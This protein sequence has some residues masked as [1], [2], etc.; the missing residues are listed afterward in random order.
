MLLR[1]VAMV[2]TLAFFTVCGLT[3]GTA[4][5][6]QV[7]GDFATISAAVAAANDGDTVRVYAGTYTEHVDVTKSIVLIGSGPD[8][9][10]TIVA[11]A[12]FATNSAYNYARANFTTERAI[13]HIGG[14]AVLT[15]SMQ[16]FTIDGSRLGPPATEGVAYAGVL[17]ERAII[18][19]ANNTIQ[20][21]LPADSSQTY[22]TT[23]NGRG[24]SVRG[25]SCLAN[26]TGNTLTE[27]NR[28]FIF[29][30]ATDNTGVLPAVFPVATISGNTITGKGTYNGAQKGIWL[31]NGC[32]GTIS[33]N[34]ITNMDYIDAYI[35]S[36]R[37]TAITIRRGYLNPG[38][39]NRIYGNTL[40]TGS[41]V[42]NKGIFAEGGRDSIAG[43]TVTGFRFGIQLDDEDSAMVVGNTVTGGQI[44]VMVSTTT[45]PQVA[46]YAITI[47]GSPAAKN[48]ITG[49]DPSSIGAAIAL[50]FRD[51]VA[52]GT[53]MSSIPVDARYNDLGVYS[54]AEVQ[55]RIWDRA[56]TTL[57]GVDTVY[58]H[59]FYTPKIRASV[60]VFLQGPY[61]AG[62]DLM[63][64]GLKTSGV[65]ATHFGATPFP[66]LAVDSITIE[67]RSAATAAGSTT[68]LYA[69]AWLLTDGSIRNFSD[70]T[71][72][73]VEF[74]TTLSGSYYLVVR[75]RNHL[76]IMCSTAHALDGGTSP[77]PYDFSTGQAQAYGTNPL[78]AVGT[79]YAM[80][81]GDVT[82]NG[83][84][85]Y[86][87]SANDRAPILTRVGGTSLT[88]TVN[89]YYPEDV[90]LNGQV[91]YSGSAND[92][93]VILTNVGGTS[94]TATRSTQVP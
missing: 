92:R 44:G 80:Y 34:T 54:E 55:E 91:K 12:D 8:T 50:S 11:P 56:D 6:L 72:T 59:P 84:L 81:C 87:G 93:A 23:Y 42:N 58:Y 18:T 15:V 70:T 5:T 14:S 68:R 33:G 31:N 71:K 89:G 25:D 76:A 61:N 78:V 74:D 37:A 27:I 64:N 17:A 41:F 7:P 9:T 48:T 79:R 32:L 67:L 82:G 46:A 66:G 45:I 29:I 26:I 75:H 36:D 51:P 52:D 90:N 86:S 39:R 49:Q 83:Q 77:V 4:A 88:A 65:L 22:N 38:Q 13:V 47:G 16:G 62:T 43:N 10:T 20:N 24:I 2:A 30:N 19:F 40:T 94:L 69:P 21:I 3:S 73:Y 28:Y 35:E 57:A 1:G 63:S 85:K 53:F 60:K